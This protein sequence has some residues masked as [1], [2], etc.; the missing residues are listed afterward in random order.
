[1]NRLLTYDASLEH[2]FAGAGNLH[3]MAF[4]GD[5]AESW[6]I[7]ADG[8]TYTFHLVKGAKWQNIPPVNGREF[9]SDDAVYNI[10]RFRDG[11]LSGP[12][13]DIY[14]NVASVEA[15]DKYTV[16]FKMKSVDGAFIYSIVSPLNGFV[17]K[18]A[19]DDGS[20]NNMPIGTGAFIAKEYVPNDHLFAEKNPN[21][22]KKGMPYLDR[23]EWFPILDP[24]ARIAA[25]RTGQIDE[26]TYRGWN[27]AKQLLDNC[28]PLGCSLYVNEQN[29]AATGYLAFNVTKK[30][31]DDI[32]V[33]RAIAMSVDYK[34]AIKA[35]FGGN[36][37][38]GFAA[39]PTDWD[40]GRGY[41]RTEKDAPAWYHYNPEESK[42]LLKEAGYAPGSLKLKMLMSTATTGVMPS[43]PALYIEY[44]KAVG[45]EIDP[46]LVDATTFRTKY[47]AGDWDQLLYGATTSGGGS[48]LND[49]ASIL[50]TGAP[51]NVFGV[52]DPKLDE[53]IRAQRVELDRTK[54]EQ[55]GKQ[56]ADYDYENL[57]GRVWMPMG[58]FYHFTRPWIQGL[59]GN[60]VYYWSTYFGLNV[61]EETWLDRTRMPAGVQR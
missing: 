30:P 23:V 33:R 25:F 46:Q 61:L 44:L 60:D 56:I 39:V 48:D 35:L 31:F 14:K 49:W 58:L 32:R 15:P 51:S 20:I 41:P 55:I 45:I 54:R 10:E 43:E 29:S 6:D 26:Y 24:A 2:A 5:L 59:V 22:F 28:G 9:T 50:E 27:D 13:A 1:M 47:Y 4:K 19:V 36:G 57:L 16:V 34:A 52:S 53:L 42:R 21:Y 38:I 3:K 40:G 17:P 8:K 37:R 12:T 11:K 18:E 7:S